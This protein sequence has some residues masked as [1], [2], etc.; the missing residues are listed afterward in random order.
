MSLLLDEAASSESH[1]DLIAEGLRAHRNF[2]V[3]VKLR[4]LGRAP[5]LKAD[6]RIDGN[7][8]FGQLMRKIRQS[9]KIEKVYTYIHQSFSPE[10]DE[11][12]ADLYNVFRGP[13][14]ILQ[15]GYAVEPMYS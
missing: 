14:P 2:R 11:Y 9:L 13:G 8:C 10:P 1:S 7:A 5:Q 12:M 3:P 15:I 4:A 6:F